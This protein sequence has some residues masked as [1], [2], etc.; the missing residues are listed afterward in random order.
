MNNNIRAE[1]V[2]LIDNKG[3][4]L[5]VVDIKDALSRAKSV[6]LDLVQ[7]S[8]N[9]DPVV[10]KIMNYGKFIFE[11]KQKLS[12]PKRHK[13]MKIKEIK[14]RPVTDDFDYYVKI[15]KL[16]QFIKEGDKIKVT[17]RF[18]GRE[19]NYKDIVQKIIERIENDLSKVAIIESPAKIEGLQITIIFA[20]KNF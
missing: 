19:I 12:K 7:V 1:K 16:I 3:E 2:R 4:Q 13:K 11:K 14:L 6:G 20:P 10:C 8:S 15:R 17:I 5:G 18:R 9:T